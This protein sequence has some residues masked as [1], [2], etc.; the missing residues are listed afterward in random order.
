MNRPDRV[1]VQPAVNSATLTTT[2][3]RS[4]SADLAVRLGRGPE[5][6]ATIRRLGRLA[7]ALY[8]PRDGWRPGVAVA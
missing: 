8:R 3:C 1:L 4:A 2:A 6:N 5:D 7:F